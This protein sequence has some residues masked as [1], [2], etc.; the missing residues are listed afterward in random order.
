MKLINLFDFSVVYIPEGFFADKFTPLRIILICVLSLV[1]F[2]NIFYYG[3]FITSISLFLLLLIKN[4]FMSFVVVVSSN[5]T[6]Y[7][8]STVVSSSGL[9]FMS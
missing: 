8:F 3:I 6:N 7:L 1:L 4:F 9:G 5:T 2:G